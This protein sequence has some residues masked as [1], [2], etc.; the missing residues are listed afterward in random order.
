MCEPTT[1]AVAGLTMS[2]VG[3]GASAYGQYQQGKAA[4]A[5]ANAA[6][7]QAEYDAQQADYNAK[8]TEGQIAGVQYQQ[9]VEAQKLREQTSQTIGEGRVGMAAG[10]VDLSVGTP[11]FW[12][13]AQQKSLSRDLAINDYNAGQQT[14]E[15]GQ[16]AWNYQA[17]A[18]SMRMSAQNYRA[19]GRNAYQAGKLGAATS[20]LAGA[21]Q[22]ALGAG[23]AGWFKSAPSS[24]RNVEF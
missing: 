24:S 22:I 15:I 11:V 1:L 4:R 19:S 8:V 13:A 7:T 3:T 5:Q 20:L 16:Q 18:Q 6:A 17:N 12:E 2:A 21:G 10:N 9:S 23:N 14:A